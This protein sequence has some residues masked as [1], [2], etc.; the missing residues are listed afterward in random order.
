M[1]VSCRQLAGT[2]VIDP[3]LYGSDSY[4]LLEINERVEFTTQKT[5]WIGPCL[6]GNK[7][8]KV[9]IDWTIAKCFPRA[10]PSTAQIG[11]L[12][13]RPSRLGSQWAACSRCRHQIG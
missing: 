5:L 3:A 4:A 10:I 6:S 8:V 7:M 12:V 9:K 2:F 1:G 13:D 11:E